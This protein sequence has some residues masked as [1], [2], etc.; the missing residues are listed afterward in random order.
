MT[1]DETMPQGEAPRPEAALDDDEL[2]GIT[3][4]FDAPTRNSP[5]LLDNWV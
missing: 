4:G 3:G 1:P 2:D 5:S